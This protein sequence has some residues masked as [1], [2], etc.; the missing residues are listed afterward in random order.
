MLYF[1][2]KSTYSRTTEIVL[3]ID[4]NGWILCWE[5]ARKVII[6]ITPFLIDFFKKQKK[7]SYNRWF[8]FIDSITDIR[9]HPNNLHEMVVVCNKNFTSPKFFHFISEQVCKKSTFI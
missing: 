8:V 1:Q 9:I 4:P 3:K 6:Y 7:I 5:Y 2:G